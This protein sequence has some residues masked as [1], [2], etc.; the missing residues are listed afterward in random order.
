MH[1]VI[2]PFAK[3]VCISVLRAWSVDRLEVILVEART[4]LVVSRAGEQ[5]GLN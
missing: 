1:V 4:M 5:A 2:G 3:T